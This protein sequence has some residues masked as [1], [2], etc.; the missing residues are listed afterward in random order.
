MKWIKV[1]LQSTIFYAFYWVGDVIQHSFSL[2]VSGSILGLLLLFV[3]LLTGI[4]RPQ[5]I[6]SGTGFFQKYMPIFFIPSTVGI[7][8]YLELFNGKGLMLIPIV[9]VSSMITLAFAAASSYFVVRRREKLEGNAG[10][11]KVLSEGE[12]M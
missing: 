5:W 1:I 7:M 9:V 12:V 2:P 11:K 4:I 6:E 10:S 3:C 8:N